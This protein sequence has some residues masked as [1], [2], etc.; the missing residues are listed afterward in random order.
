MLDAHRLRADF[1]VFDEL[2]NGKPVAFLDSAASSQKPTSVMRAMDRY[3]ETSHANVHR[4]AYSLAEAATTL[5]LH[6]SL[7]HVKATH[8]PQQREHHG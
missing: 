1:A 6:R 2:V 4:A 5:H 7:S 3:Y 8:T